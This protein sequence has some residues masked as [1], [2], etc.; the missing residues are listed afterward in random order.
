[1]EPNNIL[2]FFDENDEAVEFE[3]I[4]SFEIADK[5][6]AALATPEDSEDEESEVYIMRI[7]SESSGEDIFVS[8]ED[9][10]E[11]DRAFQMFKDRCSEEFDIL[12]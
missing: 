4:D 6:Y 12:D 11:L 7:E 10:D 1:M 9:D 3:I 2:T 5:K 8:I